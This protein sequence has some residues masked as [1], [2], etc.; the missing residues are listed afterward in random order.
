MILIFAISLVLNLSIY[1]VTYFTWKKTQENKSADFEQG[2]SVIVASHNDL[3]V[4]KKVLQDLL[5][6]KYQ[7]FEIIV[8]DDRSNDGT[9]EYL[10]EI[11]HNNLK[12]ITISQVRKELS[13]KKNALTQGIQSAKYEKL[14]FTDADCRL[15]EKWLKSINNA[16]ASGAELVLG[17]GNY[18]EKSGLLNAFIQYET[19]TTMLYFFTTAKLKMPH[20]ALG[21]NIAYKKPLWE[22][23]NGFSSH[24]RILSGDDDLFVNSLPKNTKIALMYEKESQTISKPPETFRNWFNQKTRHVSAGKA[25]SLRSKIIISTIQISEITL[26]L[27]FIILLTF[28]PA[29]ISQL[30]ALYIFKQTIKIFVYKSVLKKTQSRISAFSLILFE[31]LYILY[32]LLLVPYSFL[33][34]PKWKKTKQF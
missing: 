1:F 10:K 32:N 9:P 19:F 13:P 12:I 26:F 21:R 17:V 27:S 25:Y 2:I 15:S 30:A 34:K 22:K 24:E 20:M 29:K 31:V 16:F 3:V 6:Q 18:E 23:V 14:A 5:N 4:L 33:I 11:K 8:V 7:E 28:N